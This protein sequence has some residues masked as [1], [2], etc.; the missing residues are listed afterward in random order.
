MQCSF[1]KA[2][3]YS[4]PIIINI[5][6]IYFMECVCENAN[7]AAMRY[8]DMQSY[9]F[10]TCLSSQ[11]T[12]NI[13]IDNLVI[14]PLTIPTFDAHKEPN[15]VT[16]IYSSHNKDISKMGSSN[17]ILDSHYPALKPSLIEH[18]NTLFGR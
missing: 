7:L 4:D 8:G 6:V 12:T 16:I 18:N 13:V 11:T 17:I 14:P 15:I 3:D 1:Y 2:V 9:G 5:Y 10:N